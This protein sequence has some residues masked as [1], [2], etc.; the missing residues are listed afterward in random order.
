MPPA[1]LDAKVSIC[2]GKFEYPENEFQ[3]IK[4]V[5]VRSTKTYGTG[6]SHLDHPPQNVATAYDIKSLEADQRDRLDPASKRLY[7]ADLWRRSREIRGGVQH[8][9]STA[10]GY[11]R[12]R[13]G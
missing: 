3:G 4:I 2:Q 7:T 6:Q 10:P 12:R 5:L 13:Q 11:E 1:N 8:T 9:Q